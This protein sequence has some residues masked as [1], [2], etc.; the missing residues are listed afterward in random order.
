MFE[1]EPPTTSLSSL[2]KAVP[3]SSFQPHRQTIEPLQLSLRRC[4]VSR[5]C[6]KN[7]RSEVSSSAFDTLGPYSDESSLQPTYDA[8]RD[9]RK[10]YGSSSRTPRKRYPSSN[11]RSNTTPS[12]NRNRSTYASQYPDRSYERRRPRRPTQQ[13]SSTTSYIPS[14]GP[15]MMSGANDDYH[16]SG[17]D[18]DSDSDT[19]LVYKKR[20][21]V[22]KRKSSFREGPITEDDYLPETCFDSNGD[23]TE[24]VTSMFGATQATRSRSSRRTKTRRNGV[25]KS[26][27]TTTTS[28]RSTGTNRGW[29]APQ[30]AQEE[31]DHLETALTRSLNDQSRRSRRRR[32]DRYCPY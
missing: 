17:P 25:T 13:T 20:K 29:A 4:P 28:T 22:G 14:A 9:Y 27:R 16:R 24:R 1:K 19:S 23:L 32:R 26:G 2:S 12:T 6:S 11:Y 18:S 21:P 7:M 31:A 15:P 30:T 5:Y 8:R 10:R 3:L